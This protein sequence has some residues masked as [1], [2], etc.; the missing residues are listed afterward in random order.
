MKDTTKAAVKVA[1]TTEGG[2][3]ALA[4]SGVAAVVVAA[5]GFVVVILAATLGAGSTANA[6]TAGCAGGGTAQTVASVDLTAAQ[7]DNAQ[8]IVT[9]TAAFRPGGAALPAYA[10]TVALATSYQESKFTN[11][12][13]QVDHDSEGLFQQRVSIYTAAGA[14]NP[15]KATQAFLVR[16]VKVAN[17]Q[18]IPLTDAAAGVQIPA[19]QYRGLY[20]RWQP[21]AQALTS[22]LWPAAR[23]ANPAPPGPAAPGPAAPGTTVAVPVA[24]CT[25]DAGA[26]LA[27]AHG[28]GNNVAGTTHVPAG[29]N[30]AGSPA[31]RKAVAYALAQLGK[32]YVFNTAGPASFDCSGLT[33]AAWA[34]AGV[35]LDHF[36]GS[37]V[38]AGTPESPDLSQAVAGDLVLIPGSDGTMAHPGHV[39]MIIGYTNTPAGRRLYLVQAPMTGMSVEV[40]DISEWAGQIAAVRHIG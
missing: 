3:A 15:V 19:T 4:F 34:T 32:P 18:T 24:A 26:G 37:Q 11:S 5:I 13:R 6:A 31:G 39:G 28:H 30:I 14:A 9:A 22:R 7:M 12:T 29:L 36:T 1:A 38:S 33:M 25:G 35:A 10:A 40:T 20:A 2:H 27:P 21:M 23:A 16:L 8:A 17:W